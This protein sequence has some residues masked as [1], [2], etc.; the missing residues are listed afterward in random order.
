LTAPASDKL[1]LIK[2]D[3]LLD[4]TG[5][6]AV[7]NGAVLISGDKIVAAGRA[8]QVAAP[9]GAPVETI[10]YGGMTIMPGM[11]D[12]HTHHNGFGDGRV[13]DT[14]G[15]MADEILAL[16]SARNAHASLF[17]GVT[18]I[19]ENGPKA[20]TMLRLREAID[21]GIVTGPRMVLCGRAVSIIG[22][23]M[24]F[25]G[26]VATGENEV[27]AQVRRLVKEGADYIKV[28][29]TGGTTTTSSPLLPSFNIDE[30]RALT[31]TAHGLGKLT[32]AHCSSTQG[33]INS[34]DAGIDMIIHCIFREADGSNAF[35]RNVVDRIA[36]A[37]TYVNPTLAVQQAGVWAL[38]D[39]K[40]EGPFTKGEQAKLDDA[41]KN[42]EQRMEDSRRM[43]D[44]GVKM[45]TGSDSSWADY[46]LGN[47]PYETELLVEAGMSGAAAVASITG[48]AA[49]SLGVDDTV[50]TL[51]PGKMADVVLINGRPDERA[52]DLWNVADVFL[53]GERIDRG[54][55]ESRAT[56]TQHRPVAAHSH[57]H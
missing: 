44:M 55:D 15:D 54:S 16:Q 5:G 17:T 20:Y 23:H 42:F 45:I 52:A 28:T 51:E 46:K 56:L 10:N 30:L 22:G 41:Q 50:G 35:N 26:T 57:E 34:L 3:R 37:G 11:V 47:A 4:G 38:L 39:K 27:R 8:T 7:E 36:E 12:C 18:T 14:L 9:E 48:D 49:R 29:A 32:A 13:G 31:D 53:G 33:T 40:A 43:L 1:L 21:E 19:R 6:P 24:G 2:A 25:F